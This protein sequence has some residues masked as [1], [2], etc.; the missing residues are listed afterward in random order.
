MRVPMPLYALT[1]FVSAFLLFLVQP[2]MAKQILPWFGGSAAVWT[3]CL[4]FFQTTLLLGYAYADLIVRRLSPRSQVGVHVALLVASCLVL[5]IVPGAQ[6]KPLGSENPSLLILGLLAA[7]IG[8]PYL[9]LST[10]SPLVQAWFARSFPGR[11]P[12]RLFALS[13]LASMLA[14]IGYPFGLE[15]WV[16]TRL[17]SYGWSAAYVLFVVLCVG[18]GWYSLRTPAAARSPVQPED[19]ANPEPSMDDAPPAPGRQLLWC[20]LAAMGSFLLLAVSNHIC[21]NIAAIPL[22]WVVPLAIY[23]L[24][25]ILCFDGSGW[26]RRGL[27][28]P[29]LAAALGVMGWTLADRDLAHQLI[30]QIG[31]F[32]TGLF[33]ACMFCHG[34]LARMKPAPRYLTRFYLMISAGGAIGSALVG[35]VAPVVLPAYFELAFG[36]VACAALLAFQMRRAHPVFITLA[37]VALLFTVG[38]EVWQAK[39]FYSN[40]VLAT[41]NFYGVLRVQEFGAENSR[42]RSLI[43]GTILHGT[44]YLA[45]DLARSPTTYYTQT[46]GIGRVLES[47]HPST[48]PL[49]VGIIGLGTGTIATYGSKGDTYRFYDINP[50]VIT[51][52]NRDFTY[53]KDSEATIETALGDARLTL[54]REPPQQFDVLAIDAFSSDA[55]PM[56]LLTSEALAIYRKHMKP[57]GIIAFHVTNR[58]LDL[59]PV[60]QRLADEHGMH[61]VMIYDDNN[62]G[63]T[64]ISDWILLADDEKALE[65]PQI[66]EVSMPVEPRPGLKLWTDDFNNLVQVLK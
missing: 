31:V 16:A 18:C 21:Q 38:A 64:S 59:A 7:T 50:A 34:E 23:L 62:D 53:L 48:R 1:I 57:G 40:T 24:T 20:A 11:S 3:T 54:E 56:H 22:L 37:V 49:K 47:L 32:C 10:T 61:A 5:P 26:Y 52:A 63:M 9:L 46:S 15:P 42:H 13:N 51:I 19:P 17:Q 14:L 33:I 36:L 66:N 65:A 30:L 58:Y 27:F 39:D 43:H 4:V 35:L 8:L 6:W 25:F 12:Y 2:V 45:P 28:A 41:R 55:I 60:V 29:M 44:Q